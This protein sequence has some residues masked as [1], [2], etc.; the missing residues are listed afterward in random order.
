MGTA[1]FADSSYW[2]FRLALL[3]SLLAHAL[4]LS[5]SLGGDALGLP[6]VRFP[7]EERRLPPNDLKIVLAPSKQVQQRGA[8]PARGPQVGGPVPV[9]PT[10]PVTTP[11]AEHPPVA[12]PPKPEANSPS[13]S[14]PAVAPADALGSSVESVAALVAMPEVKAGAPTQTAGPRRA[15]AKIR[16]PVK[17]EATDLEKSRRTE[18]AALSQQ[19]AAW[20]QELERDA[21]RARRA[22]I[23]KAA[24][25]EAAALEQARQEALLHESMLKQQA[26]LAAQQ[27]QEAARR[28]MERAQASRLEA[29]RLAALQQEKS[30][31]AQLQ[32]AQEAMRQ[33]EARQEAA[34]QEAARQEAARQ[35]AARQEA[36]RQEAARQEAA[37]RERAER[38]AKREERLRAIGRQ[39][40]Q[41]A[42]RRDP[43]NPSPGRLPPTVSGLRRGWLFGRAHPDNDLVLYAQAMGR[44]IELNMTFDMVRELV[45]QPHTQPV[46]IVAV[47]ADGSVENVRFVTS[48]GIPALD[49]AVRKV[50]ASQAPYGPFPPALA[51]RYDV[52]EI[53]RT[54]IFDMAIRLE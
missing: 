8:A 7:W 54:W 24:R 22:A 17:V 19:E 33:D 43:A 48:S 25:D 1:F 2:R 11:S 13:M 4:L 23:D 36:A 18:L 35:E 16:D 39:L 38:E 28:E 46:V 51:R 14:F 42:A 15:V 40:D 12:A 27:Q 44:K 49:D 32:A 37:Q 31:Q 3:V 47:R 52:V 20:Q 41:E 26:E 45:K 29:E 50:I 53:R 6:G 21:E 30:R 34:R 5:I 10:P 9:L